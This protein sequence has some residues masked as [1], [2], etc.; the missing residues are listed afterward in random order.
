MM[1]EEFMLRHEVALVSKVANRLAMNK[2]E[3]LHSEQGFVLHTSI[4]CRCTT[5]DV[6]MMDAR[7][8]PNS[9]F[10][11]LESSYK[12]FETHSLKTT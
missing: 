8:W 10:L 4:S 3:T 11:P 5:H 6:S 1:P 7:C 2:L 9:P 12:V